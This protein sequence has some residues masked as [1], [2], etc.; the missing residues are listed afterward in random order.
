VVYAILKYKNTSMVHQYR[1]DRGSD[2]GLKNS[3]VH[4]IMNGACTY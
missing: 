4:A 1:V 2:H 3:R